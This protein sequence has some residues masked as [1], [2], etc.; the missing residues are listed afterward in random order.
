[1]QAG[2]RISFFRAIFRKRALYLVSLSRIAWRQGCGLSDFLEAQG[3]T[4]PEVRLRPQELWSRWSLGRESTPNPQNPPFTLGSA[5][6]LLTPPSPPHTP[7]LNTQSGCSCPSS[8]SLDQKPVHR[9]QRC[10]PS[11]V[12]AFWRLLN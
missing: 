3:A 4:H 9:S 11:S 10:S 12:L 2:S 6:H 8:S 7:R 1:M 5:L